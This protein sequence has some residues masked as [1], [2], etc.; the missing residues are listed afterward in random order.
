MATTSLW[1]V[2]NR[3]DKVIKYTTNVEKTENKNWYKDLHNTIEYTK[4]D[5]KTEKQLYVTGVNCSEDNA[6]QD[7]I[8]TKKRFGKTKGVLAYHGFQSFKE[9]E[10]TAQQA[11][12]IGVKLA[13]ELWGD[14][15]EVIVS[16]H[17]N[18]K[19]YHNHYVLNSVSFIDGRKYRNTRENYALMRKISDDLCRE[20]NLSVIEE[21]PC[22]K[23]KIDYT[24]YYTSYIQKSD[25]YTNAKDDIDYAI[26]QAYSYK[27]FENILEEMGYTITIRANKISVCRP[28]YKRNIRIERNFGEE[29]SIKNIEDRILNSQVPKVPFPEI[30]TKSKRYFTKKKYNL[31]KNRGSL[32][33]LYL[34]YCYLL[35]KFPNNRRKIKMSSEMRKDIKKMD[36]ISNEIKFLCRNEIKTTEELFLY[37]K[38]TIDKINKQKHT[39]TLLRRKR[40][41]NPNEEERQTLCN[42]ILAL[43]NSIFELKKEVGYCQDIEERTQKMKRNINDMEENKK[44]SEKG[45]EKEKNELIRFS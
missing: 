32:Y 22:G 15:Y 7:M 37:K 16:T 19:H 1:K 25:Y 23:H 11:H 6:L 40:Q 34:Y 45:K 14:K 5:F 39:R 24:K 36:V 26:S 29:Y 42:D 2:E 30:K 27:N 43:S 4:A 35:K 18:T 8:F 17:L 28:P 13:E 31:N 9:G 44:E 33:K 12:E 3:L 21:K 20:Y 10:V 41:K 38:E